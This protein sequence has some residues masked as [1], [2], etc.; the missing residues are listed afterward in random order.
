MMRVTR[1]IFSLLVI[2]ASSDALAQD[3]EGFLDGAKVKLNTTN[4][5]YNRDYRSGPG[6]GKRAEWG[7]GLLID[8]KSGYT[9]GPVGVGLD[10][11]GLG[12]LKLDGVASENAT[13]LLPYDQNG[14]RHA[15][16]RIAPTGN[17]RFG[18]AEVKA[19]TF[20]TKDLLLKSNFAR[21]L[22]QTFEGETAG[23]KFAH[24]EIGYARYDRTWIRDGVDRTRLTITNKDRRFAGSPASGGFQLVSWTWKPSADWKLHYEGGEL[25]DIYR[26]QV[27]NVAYSQSVG[28][29]K[30]GTELR[31]FVSDEAGRALAGTVDNRMLNALVSWEVGG[32][33]FAAAYQG[34]SGASA[35]PF[36][37]GTD[38]NVFNWTLI[39]DFM[40]RDERSWQLRYQLDGKK[41]HAP[42]LKFLARYIHAD[43]A[44][45]TIFD[46]EGRQWQ[47]DVIVSYAFQTEALKHLSLQ[48]LN[49]FFRSNYQRDAEENRLMVTYEIP[50]WSGRAQ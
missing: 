12:V 33:E 25:E 21:L 14:T 35:M 10:M 23:A 32:Q 13:G 28:A 49:G 26:Q 39:N 31:Y 47:R 41:I 24:S 2:L 16:G 44:N 1:S 19:G 18:P 45:P 11:L 46:G 8:A 30:L 34:L 37:N 9:R 5:Y 40:E 15:F 20:L 17:L 36:V 27:F 48:W 7:Q 4:F 22:P 50:L 42:G 29:G 3:G 43:H 38:G 6:V